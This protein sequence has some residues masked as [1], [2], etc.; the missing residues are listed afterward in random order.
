[1][2]IE[3]VGWAICIFFSLKSTGFITVGLKF[4][5]FTKRNKVHS[6]NEKLFIGYF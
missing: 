3:F 4:R 1:M 6:Q 2:N 5:G